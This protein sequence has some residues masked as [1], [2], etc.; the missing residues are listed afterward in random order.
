MTT[1]FDSIPH[2][3]E[4]T[5]LVKE[6]NLTQNRVTLCP[7]TQHDGKMNESG[8]GIEYICIA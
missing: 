4:T 5:Y 6:T 3:H 8:L 1:H 7:K 2:N